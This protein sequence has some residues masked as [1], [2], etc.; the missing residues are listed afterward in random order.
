MVLK[1]LKCSIFPK[2]VFP[3]CLILV[4]PFPTITLLSLLLK[5]FHL[6]GFFTLPQCIY[7]AI[8][9]PSRPVLLYDPFH[10]LSFTDTRN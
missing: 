8:P 3:P 7:S 10:A 5:T 6:Q 1:D 4:N 2:G 9:L